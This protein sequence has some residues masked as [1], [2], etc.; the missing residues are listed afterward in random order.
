MLIILTLTGNLIISEIPILP[1]SN[2]L[3]DNISSAPSNVARS[4]IPTPVSQKRVQIILTKTTSS[5]L[6]IKFYYILVLVAPFD[7]FCRILFSSP[8]DHNFHLYITCF[9]LYFP[10]VIIL[11]IIYL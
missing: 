3:S 11:L 10:I 5:C 2:A 4:R 7:I 9:D 8:V 6:I 1:L